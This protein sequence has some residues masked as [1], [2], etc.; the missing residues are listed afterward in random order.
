MDKNKLT[1][2]VMA[3]LTTSALGGVI[4]AYAD[5]APGLAVFISM[6]SALFNF[7]ARANLI[8]T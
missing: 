6:A 4:F 8:I 3:L 2:I 5:K 1:I 7:S